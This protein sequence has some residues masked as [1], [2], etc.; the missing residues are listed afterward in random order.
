MSN[1]SHKSSHNLSLGQPARYLPFINSRYEVKVGLVKLG[2]DFGNGTSD[3]QVFLIDN[4]WPR[5][6]QAKLAARAEDLGRYVCSH[7]LSADAEQQLTRYITRQL[8]T[9]HSQYFQLDNDGNQFT[10]Q[11]ALPGDNLHFDPQLRLLDTDTDASPAYLSSLDA[12]ACQ[13][14]EDMAF[15]DNGDPSRLRWLHLCFPNHWAAQDK[16]GKTFP[17]IHEPVAEIERITARAQTLMASLVQQGPYV[18][19]AWGLASDPQLDRHPARGGGRGFSETGS[20]YMR[21][22]RQVTVPF[23]GH[24]FLFTIRTYLVDSATL[25]AEQCSQLQ[26]AVDSMSAASKR[27]KGIAGNET[28]IDAVLQRSIDA[29]RVTT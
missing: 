6:R 28:S 13:V 21:V 4:T 20:L 5:Y 18:R 23:P 11:C 27:Y 7:Q 10:L 17:A 9:E 26:R 24:G 3:R 15:M 22:E 2:T 12:L 14:Q 1:P 8:C 19:F 25:S 16:I 29:A